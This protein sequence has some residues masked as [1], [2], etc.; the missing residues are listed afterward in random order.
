[1]AVVETWMEVRRLAFPMESGVRSV[2][3]CFRGDFAINHT[4]WILTLKLMPAWFEKWPD[5]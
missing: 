3:V 5:I 4:S 2:N 1:M